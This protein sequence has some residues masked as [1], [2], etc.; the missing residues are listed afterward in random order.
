MLNQ[1][2]ADILRRHLRYLAPSD[3]L[4]METQLKE[5]GL[6]SMETVALVLELEHEFGVTFPERSLRS[7]TFA[8]ASRLW[9]EVDKLMASDER[10]EA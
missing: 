4:E 5:L 2:F 6:D 7:E 9:L 8:S 1:T 3:E 10:G